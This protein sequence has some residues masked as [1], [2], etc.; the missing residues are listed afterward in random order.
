MDEHPK[1]DCG[2]GVEMMSEREYIELLKSVAF[3]QKM[4]IFIE[5]KEAVRELPNHP[6]TKGPELNPGWTILVW[7]GTAVAKIHRVEDPIKGIYEDWTIDS[8][9]YQ[10]P[11]TK[12]GGSIT[13]KGS[14]TEPSAPANP[15]TIHHAVSK[16][17]Y[18]SLPVTWIND[19]YQVYQNGTPFALVFAPQ[20][21][22]QQTWWLPAKPTLPGG[23]NTNAVSWTYVPVTWD[24][25]SAQV[26]SLSPWTYQHTIT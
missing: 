22:N 14:L 10:S 15:T 24:V 18:S 26:K 4:N 13:I 8:V 20:N 7:G 12:I 16:V 19:L 3:N 6:I 25:A 23:S 17:W 5:K 2:I 9:N 11:M 21:S 1:G